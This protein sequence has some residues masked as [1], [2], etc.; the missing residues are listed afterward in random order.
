[1]SIF[2]RSF[3]LVIFLISLNSANATH[4]VSGEIFYEYL[5]SDVYRITLIV[6]R[7]CEN[8]PV[9]LDNPA[10]IGIFDGDTDT[11]V[12][13]FQVPSAMLDTI[14]FSLPCDTLN[15]SFNGCWQ[16]STY[17][18]DVYLT[19][20]PEGYTIS[21]QRCC[22]VNNVVNI[23]ATSNDIGFT[24]STTVN[25]T[26]SNAQINSRPY[27]KENPPLVT[28]LN[29]SITFDHGAI[30][31]DED[32]LV[33]VIDSCFQGGSGFNPMPNP[34]S[35]PPYA[36]FNYELGFSFLNPLGLSSTV[37]VDQLGNITFIPSTVGDY[38]VAV[39]VDEYRNG[40]LIGSSRRPFIIRVMN[41]LTNDLDENLED[42]SVLISPNPV[43]SYCIISNANNAKLSVVN[44][45][46]Q[47]VFKE[48]LMSDEETIQLE[49]FDSGIYYF[50][51]ELNEKRIIKKVVK[52]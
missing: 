37:N 24:C 22:L 13:F 1:M 6:I 12:D 39:R 2:I 51:I 21:Y 36:H 46:G 52:F 35:S 7:D 44:S 50:T 48:K 42:D 17:Q 27:F 45:L 49:S 19:S 5:G 26:N 8:S 41:L 31:L 40:Q 38:L 30:D 14:P 28:C 15:T 33:Y 18:T 23:E 20:R 43:T 9:A 29:D 34:P 32:S 16:K 47:K 10:A 4:I 25:G 11:L 3:T